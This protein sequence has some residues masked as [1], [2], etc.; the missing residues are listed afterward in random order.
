MNHR[1]YFA[2]KPLAV[3]LLAVLFLGCSENK[4]QPVNESGIVARPAVNID[5]L[6]YVTLRDSVIR[7]DLSRRIKYR[8]V[9]SRGARTLLRLEKKLGKG[10]PDVILALNRIDRSHLRYG[11]TL[12]VP[13]TLTAFVSYSPFPFVIDQLKDIPKI[14]FVSRK[15]QAFAAYHKGLLV[16]WGPT[17]TGKKSKQTPAG[18]FYMNWKA[19]K[20]I[21]TIDPDWILPFYFNF[22][23]FEGAAFHVFDMPGYPASHAC[24]RLLEPDAKWIYRW[25]EQWL[26]GK[27]GQTKEASG[28]PVVV[29]DDYPFGKR[30]P[31]KKILDS[32]QAGRISDARIS[33]LLGLYLP[34]IRQ[35]VLNREKVLEQRAREKELKADSLRKAADSLNAKSKK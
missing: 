35:E 1:Y 13:D 5:S 34:Q 27:D 24:V 3:V 11:D 29:F 6:H 30:K 26:I 2:P 9:V 4:S 10:T 20:T 15:I 22:E 8:P 25:G 12:I 32:P 16:R 18:L 33:E 21:S 31:W 28:T 7:L 19:K 14:I 17:S 23:N